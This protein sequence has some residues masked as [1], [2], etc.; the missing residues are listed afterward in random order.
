MRWMDEVLISHYSFGI[1]IPKPG[2]RSAR[3][4]RVK[5]ER[6]LV[7]YDEAKRQKLIQD[8]KRRL[9]DRTA[10][11]EAARR[12]EEKRVNRMNRVRPGF[13]LVVI[14]ETPRALI[15]FPVS[16]QV[17]ETVIIDDLFALEV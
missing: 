14:D 7:E 16:D 5:R 1:E 3:R 13:E 9:A 12:R 8:H 10:A 6:L 17:M 2:S 15:E 4:A 11:Q